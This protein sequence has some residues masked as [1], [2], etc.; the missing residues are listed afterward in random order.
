MTDLTTRLSKCY[1]SAIHDVLREK[2]YQNCVLP[3]EI[4]ALQR[5]QKLFG[6]IFTVSGHVDKT[7]SRHESLLLWSQVLSKVPNNKVIVFQPNTHT[8]ALMG[9]Q[10]KKIPFIIK[11][12]LPNGSNEYWKVSDLSILD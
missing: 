1:A 4:Q 3:P 8:I 9:L 7:L 5:G 11:R 2:G 6:E 12:P 10:Q